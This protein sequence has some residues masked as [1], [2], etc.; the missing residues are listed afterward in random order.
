MAAKTAILRG[1]QVVARPQMVAT[2]AGEQPQVSPLGHHSGFVPPFLG[3]SF[4]AASAVTP[5]RTPP[6]GPGTPRAVRGLESI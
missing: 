1:E 2:T 3:P 6:R 5:K 4:P